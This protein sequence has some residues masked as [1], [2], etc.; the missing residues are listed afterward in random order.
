MFDIQGRHVATLAE[1]TFDAGRHMV[2]WNGRGGRGEYLT[3][4]LYFVRLEAQGRESVQKI[5]LSD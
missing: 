1:G 4:G 3:P 2:T 5:V